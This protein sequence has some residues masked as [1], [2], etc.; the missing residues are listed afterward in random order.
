VGIG[1]VALRELPHSDLH[2]TARA[3][4]ILF[5]GIPQSWFKE[6]AKRWA[7]ARLLAGGSPTTMHN[8]VQHVSTF[9]VW[10]ADRAPAV[11]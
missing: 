11:S 1:S 9:G 5:A 7:R 3:G 4:S 10:L 8:Y 2:S 6:A